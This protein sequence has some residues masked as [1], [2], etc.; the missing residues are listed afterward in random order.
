MSY[1]LEIR[2]VANLW[3]AVCFSFHKCL[4]HSSVEV[5]L[6]EQIMIPFETFVDIVQG[7]LRPAYNLVLER[8]IQLSCSE[9]AFRFFV[10]FSHCFSKFDSNLKSASLCCHYSIC[11]VHCSEGFI[12]NFFFFH[13]YIPCA[14]E[15][16]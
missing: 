5:D 2:L 14:L 9:G 7:Y 16:I 10:N 13:A 12:V 8:S 11:I 3:S 1:Q 15:D 4:R 6:L